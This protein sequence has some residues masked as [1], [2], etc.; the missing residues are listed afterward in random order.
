MAT[1]T[2]ARQFSLHDPP[3]KL[4]QPVIRSRLTLGPPRS[5]SSLRAPV[6]NFL[7]ELHR[8]AGH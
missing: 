4:A 5:E 7:N 3:E 1:F 2:A 6:R 8:A